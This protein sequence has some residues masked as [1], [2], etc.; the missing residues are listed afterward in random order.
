MQF[1]TTHWSMVVAAGGQLSQQQSAAL[2]GLCRAYWYPLYA[3]IRRAGHSSEDAKD[4]TQSFFAHLLAKNALCLADR[5]RGRFRTFLLAAL[6]H[7]LIDEHRRGTALKRGAGE[8]LLSLENQHGEERYRFEPA[9]PVSPDVLYDRGWAKAVLAQALLR[10]REEHASSKHGPGFEAL[11]DYVWGERSGTSCVQL[12][13]E[14]GISE[15]AAKKAVQRLR[16]RFGQLLR[17]Q[18]AETVTTPAE[19]EDELR[20][21]SS[22]VQ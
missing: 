1:V 13:Q 4:L 16:H 14:L 15:E 3:Y 18:V 22:L 11:K 2:E 7:Y 10:L 19:L 8:P 9:D 21:L 6:K 12:G 17:H 5:E 20:Y